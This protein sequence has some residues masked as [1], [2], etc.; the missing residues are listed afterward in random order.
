MSWGNTTQP[1]TGAT[2]KKAPKKT[3]LQFPALHIRVRHVLGTL[4]LVAASWMVATSQ[5]SFEAIPLP[6]WPIADVVFEQVLIYQDARQFEQLLASIVGRNLLVTS[7]QQIK[8]DIEAL[9]WIATAEIQIGWPGV[10]TI[11]VIEERPVAIWNDNELISQ[12]GKLFQA[13]TDDFDLPRLYGDMDRLD[14]VMAN[15]L[16]FNRSL[17]GFGQIVH[18]LHLTSGGSWTLETETGLLIRL[19]G[20][21]VLARFNRSLKF[22]ATARKQLGQIDYI[23]ARYNNGIAYKLLEHVG[24]VS[25]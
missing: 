3:R 15:Y 7:V 6:A 8:A 21:D 23:D 20:S 4:V 5:E 9:P 2:L 24:A 19:G 22:M 16:N 1:K 18:E 17:L 11:D 14:D 10:L 13:N 25:A 12:T